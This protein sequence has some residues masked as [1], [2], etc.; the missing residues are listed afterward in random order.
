[1]A[2]RAEILGHF[3]KH[4]T[5][6]R[7]FFQHGHGTYWLDNDTV[8]AVSTVVYATKKGTINAT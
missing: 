2:K 7:M 5:C 8:T 6:E 3:A 4:S 1:M